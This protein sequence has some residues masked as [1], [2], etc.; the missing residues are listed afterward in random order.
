MFPLLLALL[1]CAT[2]SETATPATAPATEAAPSAA[3]TASAP[4]SGVIHAIVEE[5]IPAASYTYTRGRTMD[6]AEVWAASTGPAPEVG[7]P[8]QI[9][10]TLPMKDFHSE[11]LNRDFAVIYFVQSLTDA[12]PAP[13]A[14]GALP[15]GHPA[16]PEAPAAP[17]A[18]VPVATGAPAGAKKVAEVWAERA[19]LSGRQVTVTGK[20]VKS[21]ANVMGKNWLHVR[22]GSGAPGSDDLTVTSQD[23]AAVGDQVQVTGVVQ[24]DQDYG[25]GYSYPVIISGASIAV[26]QAGSP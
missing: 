17:T 2:S 23:S 1:A 21:T 13:S 12:P 19:A 20:V 7:S 16:V 6:G 4:Q 10:T 14:A 26:T 9:A 25:S 24:I 22:D 15:E 5:N 3:P 8:V 18:E 11:T